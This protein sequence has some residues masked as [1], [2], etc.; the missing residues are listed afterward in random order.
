MTSIA[1]LQEKLPAEALGPRM[2]RLTEKQRR[3]VWAYLLNGGHG[4]DAARQA[5]YSDSGEACKV[6][7]STLLQQDDILQAFHE[8]SWKSMRGLSMVATLTVENVMRH[9]PPAERLKAA[10]G[11]LNRT[12]FGEKLQVEHHHT[13]SIE[14]SHTDAALEALSYLRSLNVPRETLIA[15]FGHSGLARYEKMLEERDAKR[16]MKVIENGGSNA[17]GD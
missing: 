10:F 2:L 14:L 1:V 15:Q 8:V 16:G 11:I 9:G 13:G 6:R 17:Q 3:F 4:S 7:A 5:G 12:G